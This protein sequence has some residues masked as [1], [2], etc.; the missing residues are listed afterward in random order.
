MAEVESGPKE[1]TQTASNTGSNLDY[2][3]QMH[4]MSPPIYQPSTAST[5][6]SKSSN[7]FNN[8]H[9]STPSQ[10]PFESN[11]YLPRIHI[12]SAPGPPLGMTSGTWMNLASECRGLLTQEPHKIQIEV[13]KESEKDSFPMTVSLEPWLKAM[14]MSGRQKEDCLRVVFTDHSVVWSRQTLKTQ[15]EQFTRLQELSESK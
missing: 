9:Q 4:G 3:R 5:P 10:S 15:I 2:A 7:L 11:K 1:G 13:R 12:P 14:N 8:P 6:Q